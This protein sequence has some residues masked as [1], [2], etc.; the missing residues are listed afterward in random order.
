MTN[1]IAIS[2]Q[3]LFD[4]E[5]EL[6]N[7]HQIRFV[8]GRTANLLP[9]FAD[10]DLTVPLANPVFTDSAGRI[11][12][13]FVDGAEAVDAII[14][15]IPTPSQP[16]APVFLLQDAAWFSL[17]GS[18]AENITATPS[19]WNDETTVQGQLDKASR[20]LG[21]IGLPGE[22]GGEI[23]SFN[24]APGINNRLGLI[25]FVGTLQAITN[26]GVLTF[27][28][29]KGGVPDWCE[30]ELSCI[31]ADAGFVPGQV[32]DFAPNSIGNTGVSVA[33]GGNFITV[34]IGSGGLGS[35]IHA[36]NGNSVNLT[37][38]SWEMRARVGR[39]EGN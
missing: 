10:S 38:S 3:T 11:A 39:I 20:A 4:D 1:K 14:E 25:P 34:R 19:A 36:N 31:A 26:G 18:A 8:T 6:L 5:G 15:T 29:G 12:S 7:N 22:V 37:T 28:H 24:T 32:I 13:V 23:F 16:S 9:I 33:K 2:E 17:S 21:Q 27:A 35:V 30:I